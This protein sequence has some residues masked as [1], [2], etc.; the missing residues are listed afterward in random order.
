M[1]PLSLHHGRITDK[2]RRLCLLIYCSFMQRYIT[3]HGVRVVFWH[4]GGLPPVQKRV[5]SPWTSSRLWKCKISSGHRGVKYKLSERTSSVSVRSRLAES[6]GD[7]LSYLIA[8]GCVLENWWKCVSALANAWMWIWS[9]FKN[10]YCIIVLECGHQ[11]GR[12]VTFVNRR[13]S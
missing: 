10:G 5:Q 7:E 2:P 12:T 4:C 11:L 3:Q 8:Y 6:W 13:V 9:Y 1:G